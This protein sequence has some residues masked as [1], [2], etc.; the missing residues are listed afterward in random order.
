MQKHTRITSFCITLIAASVFITTS[1]SFAKEISR[2]N[3]CDNCYYNGLYD[4]YD[5]G[6]DDGYYDGT[7]DC[8]PV[9][10]ISV[11]SLRGFYLG[12]E[13]GYDS[14]NTLNN[15]VIT[16][17][18]SG[19]VRSNATGV[20]GNLF[21]G[22]G[23]LFPNNFYLGGEAYLGTSN[24]NSKTT[25][26][27]FP[28][29]YTGTMS[30]GTSFGFNFMPG[31]KINNGPLIYV[32]LGYNRTEF[33]TKQSITGIMPRYDTNFSTWSNG[34][35]YGLGVETPI[36]KKLSMRFEVDHIDYGSF[37]DSTTGTKYS[38]YDNQAKLG[39]LF[40]LGN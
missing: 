17:D 28:I 30:A 19:N 37:T 20:M 3:L 21:G 13:G 9:E 35:H 4:G 1:N 29:M 12:A 5:E 26:N 27:N 22:Y 2:D 39:L 6:Y 23:Y 7:D 31:V 14:Y 24:A 11:H 16:D 33:K 8:C 15:L 34:I 10:R 40:H 36:Y 25:F 18:F 32:D 38:P